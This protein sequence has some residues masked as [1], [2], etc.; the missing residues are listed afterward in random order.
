MRPRSDSPS[1]PSGAIGGFDE[2]IEP[3]AV[4]VGAVPEIPPFRP[5]DRR[6]PG[7]GVGAPVAAAG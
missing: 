6:A 4:R 1:A 5:D 2:V 7:T 3:V